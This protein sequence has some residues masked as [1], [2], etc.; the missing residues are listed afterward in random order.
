MLKAAVR[1]GLLFMLLLLMMVAPQVWATARCDSIFTGPIN[2]N[3]ADTGSGIAQEDLDAFPWQDN[4]W[5]PSGTT[6]SGGD[7]YFTNL[8]YNNNYN[9]F[10]APGARVT[11][12]VNGSFIVNNKLDLNPTGDATQL[13]IVVRNNIEVNNLAVINGLLFAGGSIDINAVNTV[14]GGLAANG[15]IDVGSNTEVT[16]DPDAAGNLEL[17]GLCSNED[18]VE[19]RA[20][21]PMDVCNDITDDVIID[22][23]SRFPAQGY[24]LSQ[25]TGIVNKA[26]GLRTNG[27]DYIELPSAL[28]NRLSDFTISGWFYIDRPA[29]FSDLISL[30]NDTTDTELE[31]YVNSKGVVGFGIKGGYYNA[32]SPTPTVNLRAWNHIALTRK[33]QQA[34]LIINNNAATCTTVPQGSLNVNRAALGVWWRLASGFTDEFDG[35]ID[36]VLVFEGDLSS[37]EIAQI[38]NNQIRGLNWDGASRSD[39]CFIPVDHFRLIHSTETVRCLSSEVTVQACANADCSLLFTDPLSVTL[40]ATAGSYLN[41]NTVSL[42]SGTGLAVLE[43]PLGG[44]STIS[45]LQSSIPAANQTQCFAGGSASNCEV[46][47]VDV[48]LAFFAADG[49]SA[50]SSMRSGLA[51]NITLKAI[52]AGDQLG[53]CKAR[54]QGPQQVAIALSCENPGSCQSGQQAS[55]N[56]ISITKNTRGQTG[57]GTNI[58]VIFDVNGSAALAFNYTDVGAIQLHAFMNVAATLEEPAFALSGS[59]DVVVSQPYAMIV[60]DV[61]DANGNAN[62]QTTNSG[63]GFIAAEEPFTVQVRSVNYSGA[64]TPNFGLETPAQKAVVAFDSAVYPIPNLGSAALLSS[65]TFAP[66]ATL[67]VQQSDTVVWREAGTIK[68]SASIENDSYLGQTFSGDTPVSDNIG[69]FYPN[70]FKLASSAVLDSC[71]AFS[72]MDDPKLSVAWTANAVGAQGRVLKNYGANYQ[73]TAEFAYVARNLASDNL[74]ASLGSRFTAELGSWVEGVYV[75][76][77]NTAKFSR[78]VDAQLDTQLDGPYS[79][80]QV[81]VSISTEID[82]R[83]WQSADMDAAST[84]SCTTCTAKALAGM[85]DVRFG[86]MRLENSFGSEFEPLQVPMQT[87]YWQGTGWA[88]NTADACTS[89]A[90]TQLSD[91]SAQLQLTGSGTL[92]LGGYDVGE[93]MFADSQRKTGDYQLS[94]PASD[95]LLWDWDGDGKADNDP[96]AVLRFG[97]YRGND[98]IIYWRETGND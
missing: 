52:E 86:R 83:M 11:I 20:H 55:I 64:L 6:L 21:Y 29:E 3:L 32:F 46:N 96:T 66:S 69:R 17:P 50:W 87:Q 38:Y 75:V 51:Q 47:F 80:L 13:T 94:Y 82:S 43:N 48:G 30:G 42:N 39:G 8:T 72:Y 74:T 35:V 16:F 92:V 44:T 89:Y 59:S 61:T 34:C 40:G 28:F 49:I 70:D 1:I 79:E 71:S 65:G 77:T 68:L 4:P 76:D 26:V 62:P 54:V 88:L 18:V 73:G 25:E 2:D 14:V 37:A 7:Y 98:R 91:S 36:E 67:G 85:L 95:W 78:L 81:G 12:Y 10:I 23:T 53:L 63:D 45:V 97:S 58:P 84:T 24:L 5:P 56:D 33:G 19:L 93:G 60:G 27:T 15:P 22:L 31:L 41:S 90:A 9:L 57:N